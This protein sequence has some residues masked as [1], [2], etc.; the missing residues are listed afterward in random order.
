[1]FIVVVYQLKY[2]AHEPPERLSRTTSGGMRTTVRE[3]LDYKN[4]TYL[5]KLFY[6]A[7]I[8]LFVTFENRAIFQFGN[9]EMQAMF[10]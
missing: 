2:V 3:P 7:Q 8:Y 4:S 10:E 5:K 1:M 9:T 6:L